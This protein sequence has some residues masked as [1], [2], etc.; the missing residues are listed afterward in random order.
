VR[1]ARRDAAALEDPTTPAVP[2]DVADPAAGALPS[3]DEDRPGP[4]LRDP[5]RRE[6]EIVVGPRGSH[7]GEPGG[8]AS[9][10]SDERAEREELPSQR[11]EPL[12]GQQGK[13][14]GR[15]EDRVQNDVRCAMTPQAGGHGPDVT[16]VVE[17][18]NLHGGRSE[19]GK[20]GVDL[21]GDEARGER[22]HGHDPARV[23]R[24]PGD[25][26]CH[27][28]NAVRREGQ[29]IRLDSGAA[30]R[31]GPGDRDDTDRTNAFHA[32]PAAMRRR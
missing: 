8:L 10:R 30:A 5:P 13:T 25:D 9:V 4:E 6:R 14:S 18:S 16:G 32:G 27:A 22:L 12:A 21:A 31:V 11:A 28:P 17:H 3:R 24:G 26:D 23:L 29:K 20:H 19:V 15:R 2:E 7:S 1:G